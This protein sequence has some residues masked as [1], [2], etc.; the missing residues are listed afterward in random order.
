MTVDQQ[1][2]CQELK[3]GNCIVTVS[4]GLTTLFPHD[5][6]AHTYKLMSDSAERQFCLLTTTQCMFTYAHVRFL[7]HADVVGPVPDCQGDRF[8]WGRF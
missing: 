4:H 8:L 1:E 2:F 6:Y 7:Y 5:T 3:P